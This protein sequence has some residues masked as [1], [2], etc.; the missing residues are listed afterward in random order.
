MCFLSSFHIRSR[1]RI[2][3]DERKKG[4]LEEVGGK[5]QNWAGCC[6]GVLES[7]WSGWV[8]L[9]RGFLVT[10][11][12]FLSGN[13]CSASSPSA[14]Y[15]ESHWCLWGEKHTLG[16]PNEGC[17][18]NHPDWGQ[19]WVCSSGPSQTDHHSASVPSAFPQWRLK[20]PPG[21][22]LLRHST[23]QMW[24]GHCDP[25]DRRGGIC[26]LSLCSNNPRG[27][28]FCTVSWDSDW[29]LASGKLPTS[30]IRRNHLQGASFTSECLLCV[31]L[32]S[33]LSHGTFPARHAS[34]SLLWQKRREDGFWRDSVRFTCRDSQEVVC[35][36]LQPVSP[37]D[38]NTLLTRLLWDKNREELTTMINKY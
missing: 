26:P 20:K 22:G 9:W 21:V 16:T 24:T 33:P 29:K 18:C 15:T 23:R 8:Q 30:L 2:G 36:T 35:L 28:Q 12:P 5:W 34:S 37:G 13:I 38:C 31:R 19:S 32:Q 25:K 7:S 6:P 1:Q 14:G 3:G 10:W 27:S 17:K 11:L 4:V